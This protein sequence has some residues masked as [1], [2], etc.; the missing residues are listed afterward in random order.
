MKQWVVARPTDVHVAKHHGGGH[1]V[2]KAIVN[3]MFQ[4]M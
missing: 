2:E 1:F 3:S 4:V